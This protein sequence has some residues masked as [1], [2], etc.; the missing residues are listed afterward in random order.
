[1]SKKSRKV[2]TNKGFVKRGNR[3][4]TGMVVAFVSLFVLFVI[5]C[6]VRPDFGYRLPGIGMVFRYVD[7]YFRKPVLPK[8]TAYGIDVSRYQK[9]IDWN[10]VALRYDVL[11]GIID[12]DG[13][14]S[15]KLDFAIVKATEGLTFKDSSFSHNRMCIRRRGMVFGAYHFFSTK[16]SAERQAKEYIRVADLVKGDMLPILDVERLDDLSEDE[17]RRRV[18]IWLR[19]V[20]MHYGCKP[21]IYTSARFRLDV[22]NTPEFDEYR[23]WIAHYGTYSPMCDCVMW[24]FTERGCLPGI[25]A[26][27]DVDVVREGYSLS[28]LLIK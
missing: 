9:C 15:K 20:E 11:D 10:E 16:S 24:Q 26:M 18:L 27:V 7:V 17:L 22:L 25:D 13:G 4:L 21:L 28:D 23:Y 5:L 12:V 6:V 2:A 14:S 1:M 19:H 8:G 3:F